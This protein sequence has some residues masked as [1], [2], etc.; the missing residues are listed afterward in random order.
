MKQMKKRIGLLLA[1]LM[2]GGSAFAAEPVQVSLNGSKYM[3]APGITRLA[4]GNP[5]IA[6]VQLL[7]SGD[8][9][10]VGKQAGS[11]SLIVWSSKGR[12]EYNVYV[13]GDDQGMAQA[14]THAIGYPGVQVQMLNGKV[15]LRGKVENQHEHDTAVKMAQLY[16]GDSTSSTSADGKTTSSNVVDLLEM[17]HPSQIRLEAQIIEINSDHTKN[18]G[19]QY[20]SPNPDDSTTSDSGVSVGTAGLFYGGENFK[21]ARGSGG[22]LGNHFSNINASLQALINN[23]K[24]RIL[25]RPSITTMS[26]ETANI[27]IGGRIPIPVSNDGDVSIEYK[28]YGV[29]LN[30]EPVVDSDNKITSKVHAE[31]STLDYSHG[32]K[33]ESFSVPGIASREAD[34]VVNVHS[35]MSMVIGGLLNSEDAKTVSKIPLLGD[36]PIIGQFFRHTSTTRDKRELIILITPTLVSDETPTPMSQQMKNSYEYSERIARNREDVHTSYPVEEGTEKEETDIW[37][38]KP[39]DREDTVILEEKKPPKEKSYLLKVKDDKGEDLLIP[40]SPED[41]ENH[42]NTLQVAEKK[43]SK[44]GKPASSL[45]KKKEGMSLAEAE[46][47]RARIR[48]VMNKYSGK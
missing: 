36:I 3:E 24:A 23:G 8:F 47:R 44:N 17:A 29:K 39:E 1:A 26:G 43:K 37:G 12:L 11:T 9:L 7:S 14:L 5:A 48:E 6:D 41:Y 46:A 2:L 38:G 15:L 35:G 20:W 27:L 31:V 28:D 21:T 33:L 4:V 32:V 13:A 34:A 45:E 10:L 16:V 30:I 42:K 19:I 40:L 25:S 22:W 18:L